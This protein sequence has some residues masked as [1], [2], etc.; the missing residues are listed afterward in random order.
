MVTRT[1]ILVTPSEAAA[2]EATSTLSSSSSAVVA[3]SIINSSP[4]E[5]NSIHYTSCTKRA[6]HPSPGGLVQLCRQKGCFHAVDFERR[7]GGLCCIHQKGPMDREQN[8]SSEDDAKIHGVTADEGFSD[9]HSPHGNNYGLGDEVGKKRAL[10]SMESISKNKTKK[11]QKVDAFAIDLTD[12]PPQSPI[13]KSAGR[14][15]E[16]ASKYTGVNFNKQ[17]NKWRVQIDI[18][19]KNRTIGY[20]ENEEEAAVD[21]ARAFVKYKNQAALGKAREQDSF[22]I[23]LTDVPPQ[24]PIPKSAGRIKE[25]ASKYTGVNFN[26][27]MNK[28][29]VQI[30]IKGKNRTIGYY[31]NEEEAAVDYA[32]AFVKYKNQAALGKAREQDSFIIDLTDVPPQSPIPKSAG[33]IKEGASKYTGVNFYKQMNKWRVQIDIKGKNRTIGYYE[34]EEEAAVDYARAVFKYKNQAALGKA[35]EQD[36]FII[37]LSDVP[38][39]S[40]IPKSSGCVKEGASKYTGVSFDKAMNKWKALINIDG[41]S[42]HIGR[43][44]N[45]EEAAV[46]Y[47]RAVFKYKGQGALDKAREAKEENS[48]AFDLRDIPPQLPIPKSA[49]HIKE[50]A[51]KYKGVSFNKSTNKWHAKI[52]IE[53]KAR[54]IGSY[55]NEEEA[56][57]D[58]ARAAFKLKGQGALDKA[59]ERSS[60]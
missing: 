12:V 10:T 34:N 38:P 21:Y 2:F 17:M 1:V 35:R 5:Q 7:G 59:R 32:R 13:P 25:G 30:D 20:Y 14:I 53:G 37:D 6:Q 27:Q 29:R 47:A 11:R 48:F 58:Y 46:D 33:R 56:A 19:G 4:F 9:R 23:D 18:K 41:K 24:S 44:E 40:P 45:E 55:E 60:R 50:G 51:S 8:D 36:S 16:G 43:Y 54:F 42:R 31:E 49:G 28:W 57:V 39:Q 26:K 3:D 52:M 15:K 22:I